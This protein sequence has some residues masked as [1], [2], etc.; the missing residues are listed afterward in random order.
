MWT[1]NQSNGVLAHDG[2]MIGTG[3]SGHPPCVN[4]PAAENIHN[5]GPIPRGFW[6]F[7]EAVEHPRLGWAIP[8]AP[9]IG[10]DTFDRSGFWCHGDEV[11]HAGEEL[12]SDG[13]MIMA[14]AIRQQINSDL[15]K[16]LEVV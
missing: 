13:C 16:D 1:Y 15:D 14:L 7:G 11:A 10:T 6:T 5:Y 3:Y 9:N 12:A 8:I 2:T 4:D